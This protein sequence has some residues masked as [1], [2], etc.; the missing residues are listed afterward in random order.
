MTVQTGR[1][2][3][4]SCARGL[5]LGFLFLV[6]ALAAPIPA[7]TSDRPYSKKEAPASSVPL[8]PESHQKQQDAKL[9]PVMLDDQTLFS[10][11]SIKNVPSEQRAKALSER[12]KKIARDYTIRADSVK[13]EDSD[14]STDIVAGDQIIMIVI[15]S[16]AR[17]EGR[18]RQDLA[19]E[20]AEKIRSAVEKYRAAYSRESILYGGLY[21]VIAT[22]A[23]VAILVLLIR[24]FRGFNNLFDTKYKARIRSIHIK[25]VELVHADRVRAAIGGV[26]SI[27]RFAA[28][29]I[30]AY[31][32]LH[33]VLSFFPWTRSFADSLLNYVL[34]PLKIIGQGIVKEVPKL[35][36]LAVLI[37][38]T[39]Y[40]L[41]FMHIIFAEIEKGTVTFAGFYPEWAKPTDR[42]LTF[43]VIAFAAV[44]AFPYIPGS[45]SPAFKGISI[46]I[47]VLFSLGS[48]SS[49]ANIIAGYSMT[50]R[51]AFR[52]GD[53]IKVDD[54]TGDVTDVRLLV[55]HLRTIKNEDI[56]I[57]NSKILNSEIVN[58]STYARERG[59]ILH[60][61][62]GIGYEVSWRQVEAM[63]MLA[64]ERTP[65]LLK[66]PK[67]FV[68]QKSLGD[69]AVTYELNV[70]VSD[71]HGMA[72]IYSE[73]HKNI[74]DAFNE[75][76]VQIMT[77]AYEGDPDQPK[78][79]PKD[80]W[81]AAPA[82]PS[83]EK[84]MT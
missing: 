47:G 12:I 14:I 18:D 41:K 42:L 57:P 23:F 30:L 55:T 72:R 26:F 2:K 81:F 5:L 3:I 77:P 63:M 28:V 68:L 16:D 7:Q 71:P 70:Y 24:L 22:V 79:V 9:S 38:V 82:Q 39:R 6:F 56:I 64:A 4:I 58:Y 1:N 33:L 35:F 27:V 50:Y 83:E 45:E 54:I 10:V 44:V 76:G 53:R 11:R 80:K 43:A 69:F 75:Y 32:Y 67:P 36:F 49:I 84:D 46:F 74:L 13:T 19:Q 78:V 8:K 37:L 73:L 17:P 66:D 20:Y 29:L 61:T 62:V 52:V 60:T 31:T 48:Q 25:S 51:R 21:T 34:V 59:L 40:L 15:D 65:G